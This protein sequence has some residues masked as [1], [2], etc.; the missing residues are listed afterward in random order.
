MCQFVKSISL[1]NE[2]VFKQT[3]AFIV[4]HT[5]CNERLNVTFCFKLYTTHDIFET[6]KTITLNLI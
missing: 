4:T 2:T 3:E 1:Y 6:T 5:A